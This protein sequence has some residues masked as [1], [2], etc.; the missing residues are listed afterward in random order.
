[1][2]LKFPEDFQLKE[3]EASGTRLLSTWQLIWYE[4]SVFIYTIIAR[5]NSKIIINF[6]IFSW[7]LKWTLEAH[8]EILFGVDVAS[9]F[10]FPGAFELKFE[11]DW[12]AQRIRRRDLHNSRGKKRISRLTNQNAVDATDN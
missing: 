8:N 2:K 11:D 1:M 10:H 5:A 6:I 7:N 12:Q 3:V 9:F 4:E